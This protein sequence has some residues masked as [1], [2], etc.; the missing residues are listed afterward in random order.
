MKGYE[1]MAVD[2]EP[3]G[4]VDEVVNGRLIV[5]Q[6]GLLRKTRRA[7]PAGLAHADDEARVVRTTLTREL[8]E[9][10]PEV[11]GDGSLDEAAFARQ[12]GLGEGYSDPARTGHEDPDL[13][14][15]SPAHPHDLPPLGAHEG[16]NDHPSSPALLGDRRNVR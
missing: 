8:V 11:D 15:D 16:P 5:V 14:P 13:E 12:F 6:G 7:V 1:V 10:A 9:T 3:V 4:T 2:G